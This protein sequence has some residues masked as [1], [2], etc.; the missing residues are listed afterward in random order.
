MII[1]FA[2]LSLL[3]CLPVYFY[4][5]KVQSNIG[6]DSET[7]G[8][9]L[10]GTGVATTSLATLSTSYASNTKTLFLGK[11]E[12][13]HFDIKFQ[14]TSTNEYASIK[15][16]QSNDGGTTFFPLSTKTVGT[17][18]IGLNIADATSGVPVIFPA[19]KTSVIGTSYYGSIDFDMLGEYIKISVKSSS[20]TGGVYIRAT[21]SNKI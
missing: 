12:N 8:Y 5:A 4:Y 11:L 7:V 3:V 17:S 9:D 2:F 21:A 18:E 19:A 1:S 6:S 14:P 20:S 10:I 13:L 15:I 16:E